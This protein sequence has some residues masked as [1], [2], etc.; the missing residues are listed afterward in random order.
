MFFLGGVGR[1]EDV[2][3]GVGVREDRGCFWGVGVGR[4]EDVFHTLIKC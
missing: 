1:M 3:W 2:F 4:M